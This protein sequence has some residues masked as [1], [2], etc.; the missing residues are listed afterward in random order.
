MGM[1]DGQVAMVTG[2]AQGIGLGIAQMFAAEGAALLLL[3]RNRE[4]LDAQV[5]ALEA[6][7]AKAVRTS[8]ADV[9]SRPEVEAAVRAAEAELGP[10]EMLANN[11]G[12]WIIKSFLD[13]T[14]DDLDRTLKT[15]LYG[16]W[17]CMKAVAPGMA[18]R[19][20]GK[21][22]NI[23]SVAAFGFTVAHATYAASKAA[24]VALTRDVAFEL[25]ASG[26]RVNAVAPGAIMHRSEP[27]PPDR[28]RPLGSGTPADIAGAVRYLCSGDSRYVA[29][30]TLRVAGAADIAWGLAGPPEGKSPT[31]GTPTWMTPGE[32]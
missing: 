24:I 12:I 14:D 31:A 13:S 22:V 5:P 17:N 7:G 1:F 18:A 4:G 25:A 29:G 19:G 15:N 23:A 30:V 8:G 2:A 27:L 6:L 26:V 16:T 9:A 11:A 10:V 28:A 20:S 21:I 3:D 32:A